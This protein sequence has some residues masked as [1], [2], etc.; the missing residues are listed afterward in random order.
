[1]AFIMQ[2]SVLAS[3]TYLIDNK[4]KISSAFQM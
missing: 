1:M 4:S 3:W 2:Y